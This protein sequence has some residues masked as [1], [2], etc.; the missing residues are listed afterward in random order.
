VTITAAEVKAL[1]DRTGAGMMECKKAL[2]QASGDPDKAAEILRVRGQARA[3]KRGER[4]AAEGVIVDYIHTN[5]RVGA[6]VEINCETDFV[7]RNEEFLEFAR[8]VAV[9][10]VGA[11]SQYV[12]ADDVPDEEKRAELEVLRKQDDLQQKPAEIQEKIAQGR[13]DKWLKE[14]V[15][16]DQQHVNTDKYEGRTIEEIRAD[17][18]ARTG[19]NVVI[20][21]FARLQVGE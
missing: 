11:G 10:V 17:L 2:Q 4:E 7:A 14:V 18:A 3:A 19:E 8:D 15:L 1:R 9:H 5:R 16:L 6:I 12:S 13:L 21:R 20:R